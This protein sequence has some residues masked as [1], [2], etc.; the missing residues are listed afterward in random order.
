MRPTG[1]SGGA[2]LSEKHCGLCRRSALVLD[3][4]RC[5]G[6]LQ[7]VENDVAGSSK[8]VCDTGALK[9]IAIGSICRSYLHIV[10]RRGV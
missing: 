7:D 3:R 6:E 2:V 5:A 9:S 1:T 4:I 10:I 8:T